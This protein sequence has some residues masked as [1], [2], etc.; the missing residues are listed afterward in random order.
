[1]VISAVVT[2]GNRECTGSSDNVNAAE[3]CD[4]LATDYNKL[5][6]S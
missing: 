1:M 4:L 6:L 5:A 3:L 2:V